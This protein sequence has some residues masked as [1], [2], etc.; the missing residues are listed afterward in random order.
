V[1]T[2]V[3]ALSPVS[4]EKPE[5]AILAA[6]EEFIFIVFPGSDRHSLTTVSEFF[7]GDLETGAGPEEL[8]EPV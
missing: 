6:C 2:T 3:H 8:P 7:W 5:T 1:V 4:S